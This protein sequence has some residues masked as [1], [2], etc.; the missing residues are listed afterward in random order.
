VLIL[1]LS[2]CGGGG[3]QT[4]AID[5]AIESSP[6]TYYHFRSA[7]W[8]GRPVTVT[9]ELLHRS[10]SDAVATVFVRS[11][12]RTIASETFHLVKAGGTWTVSGSEATATGSDTQYGSVSGPVATRPPT[13]AERA[14][15]TAGALR[16]FPGESHCLRF[17]ISVSRLDATWA[18]ATI[19][20]VG[21]HR[22][23][24]AVTGTPLLHLVPGRGWRMV[25][26]GTSGFACAKAPPGVLR[27]LFGRC[28]VGGVPVS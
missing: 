19:R 27:S 11:G 13:A 26:I 28:S 22:I 12:G 23:E 3:N 20:F 4:A 9:T 15:V 24:C 14:A 7:A 16:S 21:P 5:Q 10:S 1:A 8:W 17:G 2:G 25:A 6:L 18:T